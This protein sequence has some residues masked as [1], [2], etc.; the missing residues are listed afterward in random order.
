MY[1][2]EKGEK[3]FTL[4]ELKDSTMQANSARYKMSG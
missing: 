1:T 4:E 2:N 3:L